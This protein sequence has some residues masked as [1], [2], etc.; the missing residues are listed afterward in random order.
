MVKVSVVI[1]VYGVE[2]YIER[3]AKSLFEQTLTDIEYIFVDDCSPDSS[4][5][6]LESLLEK[7][8]LRAKQTKIIRLSKNGGLAAARKVGVRYSSGEYVIHCDSDDWVDFQMYEKL[9][10]Y[11]KSN[12]YDM[13]W[14]DYF[15]SDGNNDQIIKQENANDKESLI[16]AFLSAKIIG[17]LCNRLY[18]R[19]LQ[20]DHDIIYPNDNMTEDLVISTQLVLRSK[21]IGYLSEPL[22]YYYYNNQSICLTPD[23]D[24]ILA[25]F[26][27][28]LRNSRI[29]FSV[30][31]RYNFLQKCKNQVFCKKCTDKDF[32]RV[33]LV[34]GKYRKLWLDT[35]PEVN[36]LYLFNT[37]VPFSS[38]IRA[39]F[40]LARLYPMYS[41][42][43]KILKHHV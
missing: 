43:Y 9:Y 17:S 31:E 4:L 41:F 32:L 2:K 27:G 37:L 42:I 33:L 39:F 28:Q 7:Y 30:L 20:N 12:D 13:V 18:K 29:I 11:A 24:K 19:E 15:R 3:C 23:P 5:S 36:K 35:Y 40:I 1:P 38:R 34:E 8:P 22:Y 10:N 16:K 6:K 25:N 26:Y 21:K 14:C